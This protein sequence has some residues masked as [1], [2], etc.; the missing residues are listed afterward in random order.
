MVDWT[1]NKFECGMCDKYCTDS[2]EEM[3]KHLETKHKI[4]GAKYILE[5]INENREINSLA[6]LTT[7]EKNTFE[8]SGTLAQ[9]KC[10]DRFT[11]K[12]MLGAINFGK[13]SGNLLIKTKKNIFLPKEEFGLIKDWEHHDGFGWLCN[14]CR[15]RH[16]KIAENWSL[17][18]DLRKM[19]DDIQDED[20]KKE[21]ELVKA[22]SFTE[23]RWEEGYELI[24]DYEKKIANKKKKFTVVVSMNKT[25]EW[26]EYW[27]DFVPGRNISSE[28]LKKIEEEAIK[29]RETITKE[30][31]NVFQK[32]TKKYGVVQIDY[33]E[34]AWTFRKDIIGTNKPG[35][36]LIVTISDHADY[37]DED[38]EEVEEVIRSDFFISENLIFEACITE[39]GQTQQYVW[40][41]TGKEPQSTAKRLK[42]KHLDYK[43]SGYPYKTIEDYDTCAMKIRRLLSGEFRET[44]N[45]GFANRDFKF[46]K[47]YGGDKM[48]YYMQHKSSYLTEAYSEPIKI[49]ENHMKALIHL[50][51][52]M[53]CW[54]QEQ[55]PPY[56]TRGKINRVGENSR[57]IILDKAK[58]LSLFG[59]KYGD[60]TEV[61]IKYEHGKITITPLSS[62][63]N[64]K[65]KPMKM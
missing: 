14:L 64:D 59:F 20:T 11:I 26:P 23:A 49:T 13:D 46:L 63:E 54:I 17:I 50:Y 65:V 7:Y 12:D 22:S 29:L 27:N 31:F 47:T 44:S 4:D 61:D 3:V 53:G 32:H 25:V 19:R 10:C 1:K 45:I 35:Q 41:R 43:L 40:E 38:M 8:E 37:D 48:H 62:M 33:D 36:I 2:K 28:E 18:T 21:A 5:D 58:G 56:E 57:H 6:D 52:V 16:T 60:E 51:E 30:H 55:N 24:L 15:Q 34:S 42:Y 9:C 39:T